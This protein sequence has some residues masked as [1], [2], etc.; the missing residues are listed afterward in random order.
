MS[1][2]RFKCLSKS[3]LALCSDPALCRKAH[4]TLSG[5]FYN[6]VTS[7]QTL[8]S[9]HF[10][11]VSGRGRPMVDPSLSFLPSSCRNIQIIDASNG[12]LL[13]GYAKKYEYE[14]LVCNP[15]TLKWI[16]LPETDA[17]QGMHT[18]SLC[19]EPAESSHFRVFLL[20][21]DKLEVTGVQVYSSK[22]GAWTY[23]Q[24]E[25]GDNCII[26]DAAKS[27]FFN[28]IMHFTTSGSSVVVVDM[29]LNRWRKIPTPYSTN[30]SFI[31]LS[32]GRLYLLR[33][34][35]NNDYHLSVWVLEEYGG[36]EWILKHSVI[37]S[38]LCEP[39]QLKSPRS[40]AL[41]AV[42]PEWNLIFFT[43]EHG[44]IVSYDL[45]SRIMQT[46]FSPGP[47]KAYT[48]QPYIPCFLEWLSD[49]Q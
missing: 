20:V 45:D 19:F 33:C 5:F 49:G 47:Y 21:K 44:D 25:W 26:H 14:Y 18:A 27:V 24:S 8:R 43:K 1:L 17:M 30:S 29:E 48:Y 7:G 4:Q 3:W 36:E 15:A 16:V 40:L 2:C 35:Y 28:G 46:I 42:H 37:K 39:S 22:T 34:D 12:L 31:G 38:E 13:C 9:R 6:R 10:T 32:Q 11:N 23:R 41:T